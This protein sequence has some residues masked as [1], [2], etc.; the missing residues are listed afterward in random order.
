MTIFIS[1]FGCVFVYKA[2]LIIPKITLQFYDYWLARSLD[3]LISIR[4][5]FEK[6]IGNR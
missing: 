5:A 2:L 3:E 6:S 1:N 4:R